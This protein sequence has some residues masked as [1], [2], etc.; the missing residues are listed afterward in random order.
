MSVFSSVTA[1]L[2]G[3][4]SSARL[5]RLAFQRDELLWHLGELYA[6]GPAATDPA[7]WEAEAVLL[8]TQLG[9]AAAPEGTTGWQNRTRAGLLGGQEAQ[10]LPQAVLVAGPPGAGTAVVTEAVCRCLG[11]EGFVAID[12]NELLHRHPGYV[13]RVRQDDRADLT[14]L[15]AQ[16]DT[17]AGELEAAAVAGRSHLVLEDADFGG[18]AAAPLLKRLG[19]AGYRTT[20]LVLAADPELAWKE[21][22]ERWQTQREERG[23]GRW[24]SRDAFDASCQRLADFLDAAEGPEGAD[25]VFLLNILGECL[26]ALTRPDPAAAL[27]ELFTPEEEETA[28]PPAVPAALAAEP[29]PEA[30]AFRIR[31]RPAAPPPE[32]PAAPPA[33]EGAAFR[34]RPRPAGTAPPAAVPAEPAVPADPE[35]VERRK[36][37]IE[38]FLKDQADS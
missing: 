15:R 20:V 16:A 2:S 13:P 11:E 37:L 34:I 24:L 1:A 8:E 12:R 27:R 7:S 17:L 33:P 26:A 25:E 38:K 22:Q 9:M 18:A 4:R 21:T 29:A 19:E 35:A 5:M 30:A 31:P 10:E 32:T 3:R 36:A 14:D 28:A 6:A 23:A